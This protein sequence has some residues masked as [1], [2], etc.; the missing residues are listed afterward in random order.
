MWKK[1]NG[2]ISVKACFGHLGHDISAAL[3]RWSKEQEEFLKLMIEEFSFD[4]VIKHLRKT[5]SSRESKSFYTTSQDLNNVM[6]KFNLCP[7][8]RD[9]DDLTSSSKRASENN[10][11][12]G[13]RFLRMPTDSSGPHLA[14][15]SSSGY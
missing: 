14:M 7:G 3:L 9:K 15:G 13:I 6:R 11:E 1:D 5:Y 10:P 8:L 4:Y 2:T 12:D